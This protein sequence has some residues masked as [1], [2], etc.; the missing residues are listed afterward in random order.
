[1]RV[2][3]TGAT[4]FI[5]SR[6]LPELLA[7]GHQV[8]GNA[9]S[10]AGARRLEQAGAAVHRGDLDDPEGLAKGAEDADAVIHTAFDHDFARYAENCEKDRR[11]IEAIGKL[12]GS[13]LIMVIACVPLL[14]AAWIGN[15]AVDQS[16]PT[17]TTTTA[18]TSTTV[19]PGYPTAST[20]AYPV[21]TVAPAN[22]P[23]SGTSPGDG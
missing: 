7:A 9:R 12:R 3:L 20:P 10:D 11:V 17:T 6:I 13:A 14:A 22:Y 18:P 5:G 19:A 23:A 15:T 4:G 21:D 2:F 1:M 8:V 16:S